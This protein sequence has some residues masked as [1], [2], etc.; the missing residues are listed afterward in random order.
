MIRRPAA[1]ECEPAVRGSLAV[2]DQVPVVAERRAGPRARSGP[3]RASL[4]GSVATI[5]EYTGATARRTRGC[6][7]CTPRSPAP[8]RRPAPAVRR[9]DPAW[10]SAVDRG[11]FVDRSRRAADDRGQTA[12]QPRRVDR[13]RSAACTS[14]PSTLVARHVLGVSAR[15]EQPQV[16]APQDWAASATC[17]CARA[18]LVAA[19]ERAQPCRPCEVAVDALGDRDPADLVD[20]RR[21]RPL[22]RDR[23]V[24]ARAGVAALAPRRTGTAPSTS[25]RCGRDAPNPAIL[26]S[27]TTIRRDGSPRPGSTPSTVRCTRHRRSQRPRP[28][29]PAAAA[30][31]VPGPLRCSPEAQRTP[32]SPGLLDQLEVHERL[33]GLHA[34]DRADPV[35]EDAQQVVVALAQ[36]LGQQVE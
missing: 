30:G 28:C 16:V 15:V 14:P 4:S 12:G 32:H 27:S 35:R 8:R 31:L 11:V 6:A 7:A 5:S 26:A 2:D 24:P 36:H 17:R 3:T 9:V 13:A 23:P 19:C 18:Q 33:G 21:H 22:H 1:T 10:S 29:C 25:R 20:R 34:L